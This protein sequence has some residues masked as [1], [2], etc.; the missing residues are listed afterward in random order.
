MHNLVHPPIIIT[1]LPNA[2]AAQ[3]GFPPHEVKGF[4][5]FDGPH[6]GLLTLLREYPEARVQDPGTAE[7]AR[8]TSALHPKRIADVCAGLGTKTAQL[9]EMH[10]QAQIIAS[11][12]HPVRLAQLQK[13]FADHERVVVCSAKELAAHAQRCDL[14]M[15]DVPC[16]NAGVLARRPEAKYR[17][18]AQSLERLVALQRQIMADSLR[19]LHRADAHILYITCS[20]DRAENQE[21]AAWLTKWHPATIVSE[22]ERLPLGR[23]GDPPSVYRDGGYACLMHL[24]P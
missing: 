9:A 19:L 17:F 16:S 21:Q 10:P 12:P 8:M 3:R 5:I 2:V 24:Q 13:R 7:A 14:V 23:P 15:L 1:G 18:T 22:I 6:D 20:I 4:F 11:D